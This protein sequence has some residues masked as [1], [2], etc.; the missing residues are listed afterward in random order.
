M[1][2]IDFS[3][4]WSADDLI[5]LEKNL[6]AEN[7]EFFKRFCNDF[8]ELEKVLFGKLPSESKIVLMKKEKT[9]WYLIESKF[10][11]F[12]YSYFYK[13]RNLSN[14][15]KFGLMQ[16]N[17]V[18]AVCIARAM[19]ETTCC[20]LYFLEKIERQLQN[21]SNSEKITPDKLGRAMYKIVHELDRSHTGSSMDWETHLAAG[22]KPKTMKQLHINDPLRAV[23]KLSNKPINKYYSL[24]SEMTHPNFGSNCLVIETRG[25]E[26]H[27]LFEMILGDGI[28]S[29]SLLWF[30]DNLA[31]TLSELML[32]T[33][34]AVDSSNVY[35]EYFQR[36]TD[37]DIN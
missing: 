36:L 31:E 7:F 16:R 20:Q 12:S 6:K 2:R 9:S 24:L 10:F 13:L 5:L 30:F 34:R 32:L 17:F 19:L 11:H 8:V 3:L 26:N 23:E 28:G 15:L 1:R 25:Q 35:G 37:G 14:S 22:F 4:E 18:S 29:E 27:D 21:L 33:T